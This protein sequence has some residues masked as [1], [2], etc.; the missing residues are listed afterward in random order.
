MKE[1]NIK[2]EIWEEDD[3]SL[4][5]LIETEKESIITTGEN[6]VEL[7]KN[8]NEAITISND[9]PSKQLSIIQALLSKQNI[10]Q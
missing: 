1:K 5:A 8:L 2:F 6:V 7:I 3:G 9:I 10:C 4:W